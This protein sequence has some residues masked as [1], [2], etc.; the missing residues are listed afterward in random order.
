M[1]HFTNSTNSE[2]SQVNRLAYI[3][4][5]IQMIGEKKKKIKISKKKTC[6]LK[7][8][9]NMLKVQNDCKKEAGKGLS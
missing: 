7:Y 3:V 1:T 5:K 4:L 9:S 6:Y 2:E 8:I